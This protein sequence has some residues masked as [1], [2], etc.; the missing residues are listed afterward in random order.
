MQNGYLRI[1]ERRWDGVC[2]SVMN[3]N[4][5]KHE[6]LDGSFVTRY[7]GT[8]EVEGYDQPI[9]CY[10]PNSLLWSATGSK[11]EEPEDQILIALSPSY[12][13][14]REAGFFGR[15]IP[16]ARGDGMWEYELPPGDPYGSYWRYE[17][18]FERWYYIFVPKRIMTGYPP[19]QH[20]FMAVSDYDASNN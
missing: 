10:V 9:D 4:K 15:E 17:H 7:D 13:P 1:P 18:Y 11:P 6:K 16:L 8:V 19:S 5:K 2:L 12:M 14:H 3:L 20:L